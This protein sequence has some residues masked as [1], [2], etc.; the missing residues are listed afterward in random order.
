[1]SQNISSKTWIF[2]LCRQVNRKQQKWVKFSTVKESHRS[3]NTGN[4]GLDNPI[5][6]TMPHLNNLSID[7]T[8]NPLMT[9]TT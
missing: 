9:G 6:P 3:S 2:V 4:Q 1:M 7:A 8:D 5:V